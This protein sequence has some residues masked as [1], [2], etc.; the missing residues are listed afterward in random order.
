MKYSAQEEYG[1]RCLLRI[2][3]Y[4]DSDRT[5]TIPEISE[6]EGIAQHTVAKILRVL[7]LGGILESERGH[8][9]GYSLSAPPEKINVGEVL[10]LLGGKLFD[11]DF[12][13]IHSGSTIICTN[14]IECSVR[15]LWQI[16]QDSVD[17]VVYNITLKDLIVK[18][19]QATLKIET[20]K[21][22]NIS[23]LG[24]AVT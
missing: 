18:E 17:N 21:I 14:S 8:T 10:T 1:I 16:I 19:N 2:A 20:L 4:Y 12:C 13:Q 15:S 24:T 3:K 5:L 6:A 9:G 11:E 7:R 23:S 22:K